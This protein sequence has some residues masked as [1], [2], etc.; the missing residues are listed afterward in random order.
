MLRVTRQRRSRY[1]PIVGR[2]F[3]VEFLYGSK[4]SPHIGT[5]RMPYLY[6]KALLLCATGNGLSQAECRHVHGLIESLLP[7]NMSEDNLT[8]LELLQFVDS[9]PLGLASGGSSNG[10]TSNSNSGGDGDAHDSADVDGASG[11]NSGAEDGN[12]ISDADYNNDCDGAIHATPPRSGG[13][14]LN[15]YDMDHN[16]NGNGNGNGSA[17]SAAREHSAAELSA[18][19][20]FINAAAFPS[21]VCRILMYDAVSACLADGFYSAKERQRVALVAAHIGLSSAV[22]EEVERHAIQERILATRKRILLGLAPSSFQS[23][24]SSSSPSI[25]TSTPS[26]SSSFCP[27]GPPADRA[28]DAR[29]YPNRT[30]DERSNLHTRR[31]RARLT[32][33]TSDGSSSNSTTTTTTATTAMRQG[34]GGG[35]GDGESTCKEAINDGRC[36]IGSDGS[37]TEDYNQVDDAMRYVAGGAPDLRLSSTM[38]AAAANTSASASGNGRG[39]GGRSSFVGAGDVEEEEADAVEAQGCR[40]RSTRS[41]SSFR[42]GGS[43]GGGDSEALEQAKA[44]LR[45][46]RA[47]R[48]AASVQ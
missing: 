1:L 44:I 22:R 17:A 35:G 37:P 20:S 2:A 7:S 33:G 23:C 24:S 42:P 11:A 10:A 28:I 21:S 3:L 13:G 25:F 45:A 18:A 9:V 41:S 34:E 14:G 30:V 31:Y 26:S 6:V 40:L 46:A 27:S 39:G 48:R 4:Y 36:A 32:G 29:R 12:G 19:A 8:K 47:Q 38:A 15:R 43:G 16:G 5:Y